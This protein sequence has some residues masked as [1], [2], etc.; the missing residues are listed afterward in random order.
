VLF[1]GFDDAA[2]AASSFDREG[3]H[4]SRLQ[5][6]PSKFRTVLLH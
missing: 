1:G 3:R 4:Q 5:I 2:D 6:A